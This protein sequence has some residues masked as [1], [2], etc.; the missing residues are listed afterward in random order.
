MNL[1]LVSS[2]WVSVVIALLT[3]A[4]E[5]GHHAGGFFIFLALGEAGYGA[6]KFLDGIIFEFWLA[7]IRRFLFFLLLLHTGSEG[8]VIVAIVV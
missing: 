4:A 2:L 7:D 6:L 8:V 3:L 5:Y 1:R